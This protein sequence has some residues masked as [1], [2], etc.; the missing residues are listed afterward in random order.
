MSRYVGRAT[1]THRAPRPAHA[2]NAVAVATLAG[3]L[4]L[5]TAAVAPAAS[6]GAP[7]RA[8]LSSSATSAVKHRPLLSYGS[9][10]HRV[11]YIQRRLGVHPRSGWFGPITRAAVQHY[12]RRH[13]IRATG[14]VGPITWGSLLGERVVITHPHRHRHHGHHHGI[15]AHRNHRASRSTGRMP[16]RIRQLHWRA[17]ARC[18]SGNNPRAVNPRGFY[19]LYQFSLRTWHSVGGHGYPHHASRAEQRKR[20]MILYKRAGR[21][22]WPTCGRRL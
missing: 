21:G 22:Q 8:G 19:G 5:S 1:G 20:A 18:E 17:L 12:Q 13:G 2:R 9:R 3:G 6:A 16:L 14:V 7:A 15:R 11:K 4:V 10:G